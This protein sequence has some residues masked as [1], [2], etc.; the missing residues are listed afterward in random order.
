MTGRKIETTVWGFILH[1]WTSRVEPLS[2]K[3]FINTRVTTGKI[4]TRPQQHLQKK[5]QQKTSS[6]SSRSPKIR[7]R[8]PIDLQ[9]DT[10]SLENYLLCLLKISS[11]SSAGAT[12]EPSNWCQSASQYNAKAPASEENSVKLPEG[13]FYACCA[14]NGQMVEESQSD[15][16]GNQENLHTGLQIPDKEAQKVIFYLPSGI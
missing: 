4:T 6:W 10:S 9:N 16:V 2:R 11:T 7:K 15:S 3:S 13:I 5:R 12:G 8:F 14:D 1:F